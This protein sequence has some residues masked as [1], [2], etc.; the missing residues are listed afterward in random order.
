ML[1][2]IFNIKK[3]RE[4]DAVREEHRARLSLEQAAAALRAE[5]QRKTD[6]E[7]WSVDERRRLYEELQR[8]GT[9]TYNDLMQWNAQVADIKQGLLDIEASIMKLEQERDRKQDE[10]RQAGEHKQHAQQQVIKF[11]ELVREEQHQAR[12]QRELAEEREL[13]DFRTSETSL[14]KNLG[15]P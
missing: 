3:R 10:H 9:V 11:T 6:Y 7:Q 4:E 1:E 14:Q 2:Q 5:I 12:R 15:H 13:E 8:L